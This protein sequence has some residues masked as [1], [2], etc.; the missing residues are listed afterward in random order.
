M[1]GPQCRLS[2]L[3]N[4]HVP[5]HYFCNVHGDFKK[6]LCRMSNLKDVLSLG[7]MSYVDFNKWPCR[8]VDFK[9]PGS[10]SMY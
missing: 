8:H 10:L 7:S 2:I 4:D 6:V 1:G 5:C 9:G 3:R